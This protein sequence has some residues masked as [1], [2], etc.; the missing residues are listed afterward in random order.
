ML[1]FADVQQFYPCG[2]VLLLAELDRIRRLSKTRGLVRARPPK[3]QIARE[4]LEQVGIAALVRMRR[5]TSPSGERHESVRHWKM[6]TGHFADGEQLADLFSVFA[7]RI[8][9]H[10]KLYDGIVEAMTNCVSHAYIARRGDSLDKNGVEPPR[11]WMFWQ[12]RDSKLSV[13]FCDLGI[14]IPRSLSTNWEPSLVAEVLGRIRAATP[15]AA[16]IAAA[17]ELGRTRTGQS[18]RGKGL[19]DILEVVRSQESGFLRISSDRGMYDLRNSA[20]PELKDYR[21]SILGTVVQWTIPLRPA[22]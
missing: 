6:K 11:W 7:G 18:N 17:I 3:N 10:R 13:V 2:T 20:T 5:L 8:P 1:E 14:G 19:A 22:P 4:V 9:D 16:R 15:F 12:E 21:D